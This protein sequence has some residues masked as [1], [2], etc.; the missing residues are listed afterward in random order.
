[1]NSKII[2]QSLFVLSFFIATSV[3]A[4]QKLSKL[5]QSIKVDNC[6]IEFDTWNKDVVEVDAYIEGE[7]LSKEEL[8]K[9]LE[10]WGVD[11]DATSKK[12]SITTKGSSS[13]TWVHKIHGDN[14]DVSVI[15]DELK[16]ELADAPEMDFDFTFEVTDVPE[17]PEVPEVPGVPKAPDLP[18]LPKGISKMTFDYQAYQKE[19]ENYLKEWTKNFES[20]FGK[21]YAEKMKAWGEKFGKEWGERYGKEMEAWGERFAE[22]MKARAKHMEAS[23]K[24]REER[25]KHIMIIKEEREKMAKER[26]KLADDRRVFVEKIIDGESSDSKVKKTIRIKM[27]KNTKLKVNVRHGELKLASNVDN[28]RADLSYTKFTANSIN[29]SSTSIN[30]S[31]SPVYVSNWNVGALNLNYVKKAQLNNVKRMVLTTNSSNVSIENLLGNAIVDGSFGDL[32][33]SKID[34]AFTN[35]NVILQNSDARISLPNVDYNFQYK[36]TKSLL[37]H[38]KKTSSDNVATFSTNNAN[39]NKTIVVN[40]KYSQIVMQ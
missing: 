18:E 17:I 3:M 13:R 36:G 35:L 33:I 37:S 15:L 5:S 31:Y 7:K 21:D 26:E 19:G 25:E 30:A 28:L 38:P 12:V 20:S 1:M 2:K 32:N 14:K 22:Q 39:T 16:F 40:A 10:A 9:A 27:P 34:D 11:I 6:N 8:E 23:E 24:H 4:Q 29:G